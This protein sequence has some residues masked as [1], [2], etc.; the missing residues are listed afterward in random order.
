LIYDRLIAT[1]IDAAQL[2]LAAEHQKKSA[3]WIA[4]LEQH[5]PALDRTH[6]AFI[7]QHSQV[8]R[9]EITQDHAFSQDRPI[10]RRQHRR[11]ITC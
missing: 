11:C 1:G 8:R 6:A 4:L 9:R 7:H 5:M 10:L 2:D 3:R